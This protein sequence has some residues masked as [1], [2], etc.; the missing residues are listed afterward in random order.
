MRALSLALLVVVPALAA[1]CVNLG[2]IEPSALQLECGLVANELAPIE[3]DLGGAGP[4]TATIK[5]DEFG[6]SHVYA[7][8]AYALFYANGY[9]QARDR[10]FQ[11]DVL[12]HVGYGDSASVIGPAQLASDVQVRM[13][14]YS[15][16]EI[17]AQYETAPEWLKHVLRAYSDGVNRQIAEMA[18]T[19]RLPAEFEALGHAPE[20]WKP[21][22]SVAVIDYLIG[23]FGVAGGE[24]LANAKRLAA[25][26]ASLGSREAAMEA[27]GDLKGTAVTKSY[28]SIPPEDKVVSGC[29]P[30]PPSGALADAQADLAL[31]AA[32]AEPFGVP[33]QAAP[34]LGE[35]LGARE[36]LG[37]FDQFHWGS[38]ALVLGGEHTET[39]LPIMFGGPQM[40]YYK[41]PVPYQIGLH[42]AGFDASGIGVAGAPGLV[43]GRNADFAWS[44][45][46]G[47]DDQVDVV[48]LQLAGDDKR[49]FAWDGA[50]EAMECR[51]E[52]H[53]MLPNAGSP[54]PPQ[55]VEQEVCRARGMPVIAINEDAGV[56][57]AQRTTTRG[58]E[59][60]GAGM[61]FTLATTKNLTQFMDAL[62]TFPFTFNFHYAGPEG[63][64]FVH[65]GDVPLRDPALDPRFPALAGDAHAWRGEAMGRALG[66]FAVNPSTGYFLSWNNAPAQGWRTGD[67]PELWVG[68]HRADLLRHFVDGLLAEKSGSVSWADVAGVL[69]DAAT[70]DPFARHTV[71]ALIS[72]AEGS[73][74]AA[75]APLALALSEWAASDYAWADADGD[76]AYD[77]AGHAV[78]DATRVALQDLVLADELAD[79]TPEIVLD[80]PSSSDPH[81][82]DHGRLESKDAILVDAFAGATK[83]AWCDDVTTDREES[84][85]DVIVAAL[86]EAR[87]NLTQLFGTEDVAAWKLPQHH[88]RFVPIGA[89]FPDE[90]P[91]VNR[92]SWNQVVA[93][94]QGLEYAKGVLPPGN[95]ASWT[96]PEFA[97]FQAT[98]E[99]P[100]GLTAHLDL[101]RGFGFAP[102]PATPEEVDSV[103]VRTETL[104]VVPGV[105]GA[106]PVPPAPA[107]AV[108]RTLVSG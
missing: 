103:A 50:T 26:E 42:G 70:H 84:C 61:W 73:G 63:I 71:P 74:D 10:L 80:P 7:E 55:L 13:L 8:D 94:G 82:G 27:L 33:A 30:E 38:N 24:E 54:N 18:A 66:T 46:S 99:E 106:L 72:A 3:L 77:H 105:A 34:A 39:G 16:D 79:E 43:I 41:P 104:V 51:T 20:P 47:I 91:M 12:R 9:V 102:L 5:T 75:L 68:V 65:T 93:I 60:V 97:R 28:T 37:L 29:E 21:E 76:D 31:A 44:V 6:V 19:G 81:A 57:W 107:P 83:R 35:R 45:T 58:E 14:L 17:R 15:R 101:Y 52:T 56:A 64:A 11:M 96:G 100:A 78:W 36:G 23:F 86:R 59:V 89:S 22:D 25:L 87:A 2:A 1:G 88:D 40:G 32:G 53:R 48:A 4:G 92:G 108:L 95:W 85:D 98:G 67:R 69:K 90:I 62:A 49:A